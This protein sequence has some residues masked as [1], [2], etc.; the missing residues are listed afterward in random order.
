MRLSW[1]S[2]SVA[3]GEYGRSFDRLEPGSGAYRVEIAA[4]G[5]AGKTVEL[6]LGESL[7]LGVIEV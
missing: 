1:A 5:R 4:A 2:R 6:E 7:Y 3:V